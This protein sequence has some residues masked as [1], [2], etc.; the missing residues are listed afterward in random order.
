MPANEARFVILPLDKDKAATD[1]RHLDL[2]AKK[3]LHPCAYVLSRM[4]VIDCILLE[5]ELLDPM[6]YLVPAGEPFPVPTPAPQ[7]LIA[8]E[9]VRG[10]PR[11]MTPAAQTNRRSESRSVEAPLSRKRIRLRVPE[12]EPEPAPARA[13]RPKYVDPDSDSEFDMD[14]DDEIDELED[15]THL[16]AVSPNHARAVTLLIEKLKGW[17]GHGGKMHFIG[18]LSKQVS[19]SHGEDALTSRAC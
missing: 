19:Q 7:P 18:G 6:P 12:S 14:D 11:E 9:P 15:S 17:D 4:W 13:S 3:G 1:R 5:A 16:D 8:A 2:I 10:R